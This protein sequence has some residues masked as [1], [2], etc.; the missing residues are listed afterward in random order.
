MAMLLVV[1]PAGLSAG[2]SPSEALY[3]YVVDR[4][5]GSEPLHAQ[6]GVEELL[7][8]RAAT[9]VAEGEEVVFLVPAQSLSWYRVALPKGSVRRSADRGGARLRAVLDGI[10]EDHLL[11]DGPQLHLAVH[12]APDVP[13]WVSAC[14]KAWLHGHVRW[15]CDLGL[16][17]ARV[18]PECTPP[19]LSDTL[20]VVGTED[21]PWLIAATS[22]APAAQSPEEAAPATGVA[23]DEGVLAVPLSAG[24]LAWWTEREGMA[25]P[26]QCVAEPAVAQVAERLL[27]K[28]PALR[29]RPHRLLDAAQTSWD[30]AQFDLPCA[31]Q[32]RRWARCTTL[33][34]ALLRSPAWR[35]ARAAA[36][37]VLCCTLVGIVATALH[38]R[39]ALQAQRAALRSLLTQ[40]FPH[41]PVVVDAPAQMERE[42][43]ALQRA[44][45][46]LSAG[47]L[48][49]LLAAMAETLPLGVTLSAVDYDS[50]T[51]RVLTSG[52]AANAGVQAALERKGLR[53]RQEGSH[54]IVEAVRK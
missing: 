47:D 51:L 38:A 19:A 46:A 36:V 34:R 8:R 53:V 12:G 5:D 40:T 6:G 17:P 35:P 42:L 4:M 44:S 22:P 20:F 41:I 30:L 29:Q 31:R 25:L 33:A 49:P 27:G 1:L 14:D 52:M 54:W 9:K 7:A 24:A 15:L 13:V 16:R 11:D 23:H 37:A 28:P 10:L 2:G 45:G 32:D 3:E 18:V 26:P 50:G 21:D 39:S 43:A 48:E